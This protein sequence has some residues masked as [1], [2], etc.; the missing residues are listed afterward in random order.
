MAEYEVAA[1]RKRPES[2]NVPACTELTDRKLVLD[3][4]TLMEADRRPLAALEQGERRSTGSR[5]TGRKS[6]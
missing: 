4:G 6:D 2:E 5:A 1:G 3:T